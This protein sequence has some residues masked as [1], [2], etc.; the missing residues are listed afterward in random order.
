[1]PGASNLCS[2][3][4]SMAIISDE[5]GALKLLNRLRQGR[6]FRDSLDH[7]NTMLNRENVQSEKYRLIIFVLRKL[8]RLN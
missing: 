3:L 6:H 1:M 7:S 4:K 8:R 2:Y 5:V